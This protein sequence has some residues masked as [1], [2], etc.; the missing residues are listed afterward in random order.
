MKELYWTV[1]KNIKF[2]KR[3]KSKWFKTFS[4]NLFQ[5]RLTTEKIET[6]IKTETKTKIWIS[7]LSILKTRLRLSK[8]SSCRLIILTFKE[9][10]KDVSNLV[11]LH[12]R[13]LWEVSIWISFFQRFQI[14][15]PFLC[16][17]DF[18]KFFCSCRYIH[19]TYSNSYL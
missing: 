3:K 15:H 18:E 14:S 17:S 13:L 8:L 4:W 1:K 16:H 12:P 2:C 5:A 10:V 9:S 7:A 6:E 11:I 19:S